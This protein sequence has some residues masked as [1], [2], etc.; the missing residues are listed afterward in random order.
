[1]LVA[2]EVLSLETPCSIPERLGL[3]AK[4]ESARHHVSQPVRTQALGTNVHLQRTPSLAV[5]TR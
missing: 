2:S 4:L 3:S 5:G 1:M